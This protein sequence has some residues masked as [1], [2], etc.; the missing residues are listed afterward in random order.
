MPGRAVTFDT[1]LKYSD[2]KLK[3]A[4]VAGLNA[5]DDSAK[6]IS[7]KSFGQSETG[8]ATGILEKMARNE[9]HPSTDLERFFV[10]FKRAAIDA[11]YLSDGGRKSLGYRGD[12]AIASF[13]GCTHPEHKVAS[14]G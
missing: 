9:T 8:I 7:G 2:D 11:F 6:A 10:L 3:D 13:P 5:V 12:T 4:W 1:V 14:S